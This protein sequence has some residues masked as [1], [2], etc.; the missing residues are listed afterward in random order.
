MEEGEEMVDAHEIT[1][2]FE[3]PRGS[4]YGLVKEGLIRAHDVTKDHHRRRQLR[5][6]ASEVAEDVAKIKAA[7]ARRPDPD[8]PRP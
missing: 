6:Y 8:A 2:R 1:T 4:L 5:F 3:I 7:R